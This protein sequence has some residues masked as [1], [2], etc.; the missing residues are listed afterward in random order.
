MGTYLLGVDVVYN[1]IKSWHPRLREMTIL[2]AYPHASLHTLG[3]HLLSFGS[4]TLPQGYLHHRTHFSGLSS[5]AGHSTGWAE[6][7]EEEATF[8]NFLAKR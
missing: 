2:Q 1:A 8:S 3:Q 4:L 6:R 5:N 7:G